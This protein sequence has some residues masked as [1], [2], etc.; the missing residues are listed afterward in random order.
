VP[1]HRRQLTSIE[2][3]LNSS[4]DIR[5]EHARSLIPSPQHCG[6]IAALDNTR[7][8]PRSNDWAR[9][10]GVF[11]TLFVQGPPLFI[12]QGWQR[13]RLTRAFRTG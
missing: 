3:L 13:K 4:D 7:V 10:P 6:T 12:I 8:I 1:N 2:I 11:V 9:R 5:L